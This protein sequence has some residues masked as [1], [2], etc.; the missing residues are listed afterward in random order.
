[1]TNRRT[2]AVL[3]GSMLLAVSALFGDPAS[4]PAAAP[5]V[6][7][8]P[9]FTRPFYNA[10]V[11]PVQIL[12]ADFNGD[13]YPDL[14]VLNRRHQQ[15]PNLLG[16]EFQFLYGKP[17]ASFTQTPPIFTGNARPSRAIVV[18][19]HGDHHNDIVLA[20]EQFHGLS[21]YLSGLGP[22]LIETPV[23]TAGT[24]SALAS[25]DFN[26]DGQVDVVVGYVDLNR[27]DVILGI[28]RPGS[29]VASIDSIGSAS[30]LATG[31]FDED[32]LADIAIAIVGSC[33]VPACAPV[34]ILLARGLGDGSFA[35]PAP[36]L[37]GGS[38][39][40]LAAGDFDGDGHLDLAAAVQDPTAPAGG[41]LF[42]RGLGTAAFA[43][44]VPLITP[45]V[46]VQELLARDLDGDGTLDIAARQLPP[47]TDPP[48]VNIA[49][50]S[51]DGQ[52]GFRSL[53]PP[54]EPNG[55][56]AFSFELADLNRD[57]A[58]D[59]VLASN[60][61]GGQAADE[62]EVQFGT[63]R[64][65]FLREQCIAD[66]W[67]FGGVEAVDL[68]R[69]GRTDLL[70][71]ENRAF[72]GP[73]GVRRFMAQP[74]GS[75]L[76]APRYLVTGEVMSFRT[77]DFNEDGLMDLAILKFQGGVPGDPTVEIAFGQPDGGFG[78]GTGLRP[79]DGPVGLTT[80]DFDG[81]GRTDLAVALR[82]ADVICQYGRVAVYRGLGD[83]SFTDPTYGALYQNFPRFWSIASGDFDGDGSDEILLST[84]FGATLYRFDGTGL[85]GGALVGPG[86]PLTVTD[87]TGDGLLDLLN[88][89]LVIPGRGDGTF[90][91]G[92]PVA[93][94]S[95]AVAV[96][97]FTGDGALDVV[98]TMDPIRLEASG[99]LVDRAD[100]QGGFA[101]PGTFHFIFSQPVGIAA[102][103]F[104]RDGR[105]DI[106]FGGPH[107]CLA[108]N[109]GGNP[110][111]D[112]DGIADAMDPCVDSD[113]DGFADHLTG[114][115]TCA[116]DNCPGVPNV[117]QTDRDGDGLGDACDPCP[118]D[119]LADRDGDGVCTATDVCPSFADPDQHDTDH[120][121]VGDACDNCPAVGSTD[122]TDSNGDGAGDAC[123]PRLVINEIV[124]D[125]G[126]DLEVLADARDPQ[127]DPLTG[128][129]RIT[130]PPAPLALGN[131]L[132]ATDFCSP[133]RLPAGAGVGEGLI[134]VSVPG[135]RLLADLDFGVGCVDG[136]P[137][138]MVVPGSCD[139]PRGSFTSPQ[140]LSLDLTT[141]T[142][143]ADVCI[144]HYPSLDG[145]LTVH[146]LAADDQS[147][148]YSLTPEQDVVDVTS[149]GGLPASVPLPALDPTVEYV[150][151]LSVSDGTTPPAEDAKPFHAHGESLLVI[152][153]ANAAPVAA[154]GAVATTVECT[155]ASAG[156]VTLD[157]GAS[158]D[159]DSSP[160]TADDI[161][162]YDW[163]EH[164]GEATERLLGSGTPLSVDLPLGAHT[165]TLKVTDH[166]GLSDTDS[167]V[168]TVQDTVPPTL[169]VLTDPSVLWPANHDLVPIA[170]S[171]Q[172][173][174]ACAGGSVTVVLVSATSSEP[175]DAA[176]NDDGA[177]G[178]DVQGADAG[179]ADTSVLLRAERQGRGP[180][181]VYTLL[182]RA[183][184]PSGNTT[185]S[186]GV[187]TVPH[188]QG[189]GP[190]P[191]L[192]HLESV[193]PGT[194]AQRI[195]WPAIA[196]ATGYDVI[197]GTLRQVRLENGTINLGA[198]SVLARNTTLTSVSEPS[199]TPVPEVGE[200]FF[201]LV[202][203]RTAD[204]ATGWGSEPAPWPRAPGSCEGGCPSV[205]GSTVAGGEGP[206]RR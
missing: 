206:A 34:E 125:G 20:K 104:D 60:V 42:L 53:P 111:R 164:Y 172:A 176:G 126:D 195:F 66:G 4:P 52:G 112:A 90:S 91:P 97:D 13:P 44:G 82:C 7:N 61:I 6:V 121:G 21:V 11:Q 205:T 37:T 73:V 25:G 148:K 193:T 202:Q 197:R 161:A 139:R 174:D 74:D 57:G 31:D 96:A 14:L 51:H 92:I 160:G 204:R 23:A 67:L 183:T 85:S 198:V 64:D 180:G 3:L 196:G 184:D 9:V 137:D 12:A 70:A 105:P 185:T 187:V 77:S 18:D 5:F 86:G 102:L 135:A 171:W 142:L 75:F 101:L 119:P 83:G 81:D 138:Y 35:T 136:A 141:L 50:F 54:R 127:G 106:A 55:S 103:D 158:T 182:Y 191:L 84:D 128:H 168:V 99:L 109:I 68:D 199:S 72:Y 129:V 39:T 49:L 71:L 87:I 79:T 114:A 8:G 132:N 2:R 40:R 201:Y 147:L 115:G 123:Q 153:S 43:P 30:D 140:S 10:G 28:A 152:T 17:D 134:Y 93:I 89:N 65:G 131:L 122:Q 203:E 166:D 146:L 98:S 46:N 26:R 88:A 107:L 45:F 188:D 47:P 177:T 189:Q 24:P 155:G 63:P 194:A 181:R 163:Y 15:N 124:E 100:G 16:G 94:L 157:G 108:S 130:G 192:M 113:A 56:P 145:F 120:D 62:L 143:P 173:Q 22:S 36:I 80:G 69:D 110:D 175:D 151:H 200:T 154:A 38:A 186:P 32:G 116:L 27:V 170:V 167:I 149:P 169:S 29:T 59:A 156:T 19:V 1:M 190:E 78:P 95:G 58:P 33:D 165:I 150:L 159:P 118:S 162:R 179:T 117:A 144:A 76:E 48:P 178:G 41:V 133:D